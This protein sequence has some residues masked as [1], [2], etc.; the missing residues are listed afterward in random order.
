MELRL[1]AAKRLLG[2]RR[3]N[4]QNRSVAVLFYAIVATPACADV[5]CANTHAKSVAGLPSL[6]LPG[7]R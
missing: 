3:G 7:W 5:T 6:L 1:L 4:R 2:K